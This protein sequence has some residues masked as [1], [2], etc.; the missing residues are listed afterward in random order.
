M[1]DAEYHWATQVGDALLLQANWAWQDGSRSI[2]RELNPQA[3]L[4][5]LRFALQLAEAATGA[6]SPDARNAGSTSPAKFK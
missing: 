3:I 4:A 2:K 1:P 6:R 5:A